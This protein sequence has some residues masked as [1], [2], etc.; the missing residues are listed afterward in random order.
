MVPALDPPMATMAMFAFLLKT[1]GNNG[2]KCSSNIAYYGKIRIYG[3][4]CVI[5]QNI[6]L[7]VIVKEDF[8]QF[9][10]ITKICP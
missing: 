6:V 10:A 7:H 2:I 8:L 9:S 5:P 1:K 3:L 4:A